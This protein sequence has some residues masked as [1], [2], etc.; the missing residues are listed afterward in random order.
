MSDIWPV[1]LSVDP[2]PLTPRT[3]SYLED[4]SSYRLAEV[5]IIETLKLRLTPSGLVVTESE[6]ILPFQRTG[7]WDWNPTLQTWVQAGSEREPGPAWHSWNNAGWGNNELT[8]TWDDWATHTPTPEPPP[9]YP[10]EEFND[11]PELEAVEEAPRPVLV[12]ANLTEENYEDE[13]EDEDED[14]NEDEDEE[15]DNGDKE[16]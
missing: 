10:H 2:A 8:R 12:V 9:P 15:E 3:T 16:Y 6:Q 1:Q 13:D 7:D 11:L 4:P 5:L 14:E